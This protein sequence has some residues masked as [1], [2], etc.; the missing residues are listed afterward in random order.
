LLK[1]GTSWGLASPSGD[2]LYFSN[3]TRFLWR[4]RGVDYVATLHRFGSLQETRA[5]LGR[6]IREL[7]PVAQ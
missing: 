1:D 7:R 2:Y 6:L 3:H 4:E 5:L